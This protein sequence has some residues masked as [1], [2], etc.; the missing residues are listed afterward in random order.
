MDD[1]YYFGLLGE[2]RLRAGREEAA[3]EA[4]AAAL[5]A[6]PHGR[7][8]FY[9]PEIHRLRGEVALAAEPSDSTAALECFTRALELARSHGAKSLELRAALSAAPL[10]VTQGRG[11]EAREIV[12]TAYA[13]FSEGFDTPDLQGAR[14]FLQQSPAVH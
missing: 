11:D 4:L 6:A 10:L 9:E 1:P 13:A 8:F 2:A 12:S 14:S 3:A 7:Q 5:D